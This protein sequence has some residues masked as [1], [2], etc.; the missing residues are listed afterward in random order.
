MH[1]PISARSRLESD[2]GHDSRALALCFRI[3]T[4]ATVLGGAN[5]GLYFV[6]P[7]RA[8]R[9]RTIAGSRQTNS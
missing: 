7:T 8:S 6:V 1:S 2:H 5:A 4:T 3:V 9:S